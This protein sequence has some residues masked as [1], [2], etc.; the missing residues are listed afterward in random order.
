MIGAKVWG[1]GSKDIRDVISIGKLI[2]RSED[3]KQIIETIGMLSVL[4][5]EANEQ[6]IL[7]M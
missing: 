1:H 5:V 4:I 3:V 7:N 6:V 2:R